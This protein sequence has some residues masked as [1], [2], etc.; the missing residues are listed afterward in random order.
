MPR[1]LAAP[2]GDGDALGIARAPVS[3]IADAPVAESS[4][5][6]SAAHD[7]CLLKSGCPLGCRAACW[8]SIRER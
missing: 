5:F 8:L 2:T 1:S 4:P 7:T 6:P 3:P